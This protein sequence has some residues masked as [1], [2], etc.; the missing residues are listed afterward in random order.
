MKQKKL[1]RGDVVRLPRADRVDKEFLRRW[2]TGPFIITRA[3]KH[4]S[5][6]VF[7]E[8][9]TPAGERPINDKVG[10]NHPKGNRWQFHDESV[11]SGYVVVDDFLTKVL[12]LKQNETKIKA[13]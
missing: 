5:G 2:G 12:K 10:I 13:R 8:F 3:V 1:K 4:Q 7:Y 6:E 9:K 11:E